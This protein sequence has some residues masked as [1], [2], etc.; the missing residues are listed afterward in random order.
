MAKIKKLNEISELNIGIAM[1]EVSII[2]NILF[3]FCTIFFILSIFLLCFIQ[4]LLFINFTILI[5]AYR[6]KTKDNLIINLKV[7]TILLKLYFCIFIH[8][9]NVF[10]C[11]I[12]K[13]LLAITLL[14]FAIVNMIIII[15]KFF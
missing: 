15:I 1:L 2:Y 4:K 9:Q 10:I 14:R 6:K 11:D 3:E 8:L 5:L 13:I 7:T 12:I